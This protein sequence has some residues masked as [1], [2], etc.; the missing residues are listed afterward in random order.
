MLNFITVVF[1]DELP[2]LEIQAQ[3]IDLYV[4][5]L[6]QITIVVNDTADVADYINPEWWGKHASKV[7]VTLGNQYNITGWESQQL[8]KLQAAADSTSEW[9]MVLDAKTW[10][11]KEL[12][13]NKLFVDGR[14]RVGN[15]SGKPNVFAEGRAFIENYYNIQM[16]TIIGPNGVPYMFHTE[17]VKQM[18][19]EFDDFG[20]FFQTNV[21]SPNFITEFFLYSGYVIK[22][23]GSIEKLYETNY[24]YLFPVNISANEANEFQ[25]IFNNIRRYPNSVLTASIHRNT[26]QHLTR[27]QLLTWVLFLEER[28]LICNILNTLNL[29]N[30]YIK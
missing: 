4:S 25:T 29:L 21:R 18:I 3:S 30:T 11:I 14:P 24:N 28:Q 20:N 10:F 6:D 15:V 19:S 26:Y 1:Q 9:S 22:R 12:D 5:D 8:L 27:E 7:V 13:Y 2:L 17:T 16:P 23:Y